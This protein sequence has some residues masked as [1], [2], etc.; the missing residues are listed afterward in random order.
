MDQDCLFAR[1][2]KEHNEKSAQVPGG[3]AFNELETCFQM[4]VF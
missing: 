1:K 4:K 2:K 3:P